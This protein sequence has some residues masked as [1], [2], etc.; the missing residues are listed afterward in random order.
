MYT[1]VM[2]GNFITFLAL[3]M[4]KQIYRKYPVLSNKENATHIHKY[5]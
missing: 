5:S 1:A 3:N 2:T 4:I